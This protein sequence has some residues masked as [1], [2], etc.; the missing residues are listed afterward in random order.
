[1]Y[2]GWLTVSFYTKTLCREHK[3]RNM[4]NF[5]PVDHDGPFINLPSRIHKEFNAFE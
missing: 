2:I 5:D 1:V 3:I 4:A